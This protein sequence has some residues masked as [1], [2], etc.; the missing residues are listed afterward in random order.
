MPWFWQTFLLLLVTVPVLT[1]FAYA[2]WDV[3]RRPDF[4]VFARGIWLLAFCFVPIIGPLIYL[5][6]RPPGTTATERAMAE[7]GT[8]AADELVRLA[9]LHDR[10]KLTDTEYQ[11]AKA[12]HLGPGSGQPESVMQ[13]RGGV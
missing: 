7:G 10:Q 8:S 4:A 12:Q 13:Q 9:D 6:I 1:M 3:V 2:A 11:A 5:A